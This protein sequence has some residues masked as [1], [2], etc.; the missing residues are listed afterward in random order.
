MLVFR[1][2]IRF[3][4]SAVFVDK[5][6][7]G[8]QMRNIISESDLEPIDLKILNAVQHNGR[9]SNIDL[10][11]QVGLS[12]TPCWRR[13]KK[14]EEQNFITSY[15][16]T[17]NRKL[18][19]YHIFAYLFIEASVHTEQETKKFEKII[20]SR[21]EVMDFHNVTGNFD[22]IIQIVTRNMD[23]YADFIENVLRKIPIIKTIQSS[24]A[25]RALRCK[26]HLP[27]G[28]SPYTHA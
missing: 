19:G 11:A 1:R 14:L 22:F 6:A 13:L 23:E 16:A 25:L 15:R 28:L 9:I 20:L 7:I 10:S 21:P 3:S 8:W 17:L 18:L 5:I 12:A 2:G 27:I 26:G 4:F 24:I